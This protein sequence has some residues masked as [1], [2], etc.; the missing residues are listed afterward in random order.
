MD[1][2][3]RGKA[4][5]IRVLTS[6]EALIDELQAELATLRQQLATARGEALREAAEVCEERRSWH[7]AHDGATAASMQIAASVCRDRILALA[8]RP[9]DDGGEVKL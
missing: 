3:H 5:L 1:H 2:S 7:A 8:A 9:G 4:E 6:R